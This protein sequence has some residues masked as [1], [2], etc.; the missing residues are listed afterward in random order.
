[1][2][3]ME[4]RYAKVLLQLAGPTLGSDVRS[5]VRELAALSG[6]ARVAPNSPM[7]RLL[8]IDYDP[9]EIRVRTMLACARRS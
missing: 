8:L 3:Q 7:P 1:M 5:L 9:T 2:I 4:N 6:V